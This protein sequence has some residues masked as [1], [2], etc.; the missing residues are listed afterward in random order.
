MSKPLDQVTD[1]DLA[2]NGLADFS[3]NPRP[4]MPWRTENE[5]L[6]GVAPTPEEWS[7]I[8]Q[9][10]D[11]PVEKHELTPAW[12]ADWQ[13]H[14][15]MSTNGDIY[16][17]SRKETGEVAIWIWAAGMPQWAIL[18]RFGFIMLANRRLNEI[19][20]AVRR[21][22]TTIIELTQELRSRF[23]HPNYGRF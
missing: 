9:A 19:R 6:T 22:E 4:I 17:M 11:N 7:A 10:A 3:I 12:P 5:R 2:R 15:G 21:G 16:V 18:E 20:E 1:E 13:W 23:D 14:E 8:V